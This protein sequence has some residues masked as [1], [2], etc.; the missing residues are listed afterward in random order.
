MLSIAKT[1]NAA[2]LL[3]NKKVTKR[4]PDVIDNTWGSG[5]VTSSQTFH[6]C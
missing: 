3:I 6:Y 2:Y 1:T 5:V 4:Q